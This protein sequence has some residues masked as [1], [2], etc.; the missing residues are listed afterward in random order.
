MLQIS[1]ITDYRQAI[2]QVVCGDSFKLLELI[3][4][5]SIDMVMADPPYGT[6]SC[7][8][9]VVPDLELMW[10]HLKRVIKRGGCVYSQ[11]ANRSQPI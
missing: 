2:N 8:W 6:V 11:P 4:D 9:D 10:T 3:P 1:N 5:N 7:E